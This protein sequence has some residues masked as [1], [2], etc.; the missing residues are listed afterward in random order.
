M[1]YKFFII[2][3]VT[4]VCGV[5]NQTSYADGWDPNTRA[6]NTGSIV[7]TRHNLTVTYNAQ[8]KRL[9]DAFRNDYVEVCVYCHTPHGSNSQIAAPL[10]NRTINTG[11]YTIYDKPRTLNR[12]IGQP[13]PNSLTCLSCHDGTISIDSIINMPGSGLYDK[14]QETTPTQNLSFLSAWPGTGPLGNN[15]FVLG[16][17][18]GKPI[19]IGQSGTCLI[20]HRD[21]DS[22]GSA[23]D[24][25][26]FVIGTDLTNDH[27]IG[28]QYPTGFGPGT[29]FN[30][31]NGV[32][33]GRMKFFDLDG[34]GF[35]DKGDIRVYESGE[36]YEVE[37]ASC[38]DPHGVP[39]S[40][41]GSEFNPS[42]LRVSNGNAGTGIGNPSGLCLTCHLK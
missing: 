23:P 29:D 17:E 35:P 11:A 19:P 5:F 16:N 14:N 42:F 24:Y 15:H 1:Q 9:M 12:P 25:R 31:P 4:L 38:H 13:G 20:C 36:G 26:V 18:V 28:I 41:A 33:D 32:L 6:S 39:S 30:T 8:N 40:G 37:C 10:W 21:A 2:S 7:N 3:A 27:P 22:G 34:N